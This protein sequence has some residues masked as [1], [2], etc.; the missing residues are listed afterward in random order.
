MV[1]CHE[2]GGTSA[3]VASRER[4]CHVFANLTGFDS[5]CL[6]RP[7]WDA[8]NLRLQH[9]QL[10]QLRK[11]CTELEMGAPCSRRSGTS[12]YSRGPRYALQT[13]FHE[14]GGQYSVI[15]ATATMAVPRLR[16]F[17]W[18]ACV[19]EWGRAGWMGIDI[20]MLDF[21]RGWWKAAR[22]PQ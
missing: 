7:C 6:A 3:P 20:A 5:G 13:E 8:G 15:A 10:L 14:A 22:A 19:A 11:L 2:T 18:N 12:M 17:T 1:K 21:P 16:F 4:F 9:R